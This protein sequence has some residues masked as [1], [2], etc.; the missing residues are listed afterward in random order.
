M[1][2]EYERWLREHGTGTE[3]VD[4]SA[5]SAETV[6]LYLDDV[7]P[8]P[9]GW[10]LARTVAEAVAIMQ[11]FTVTEASLDHDL[12]ACDACMVRDPLAAMRLHCEHV[13]DG[14]AFVRW[15]V[16]TGCWPAAAP[17]VHSMNPVGARA[18]RDL[19]A[20]HWPG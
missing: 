2:D 19:I 9:P 13:P 1:S 6:K 18:M 3:A 12:G 4:L 20:R 15:M 17:V 11:R 5:R 7:R 10:T 16:A 14:R 8:C